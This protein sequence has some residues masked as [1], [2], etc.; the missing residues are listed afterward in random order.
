MGITNLKLIPIF[1]DP[2][3]FKI[4]IN[5]QKEKKLHVVVN[6]YSVSDHSVIIRG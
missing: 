3:V 4:V 1:G 2:G 6:L 5:N